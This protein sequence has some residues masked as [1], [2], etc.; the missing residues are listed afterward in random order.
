MHTHTHAASSDKDDAHARLPVP[1]YA[2]A[3]LVLEWV[4]CV[5]SVRVRHLMG[6]VRWICTHLA[7]IR[8]EDRQV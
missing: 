7:V 2:N 1:I 5:Y 4:W 8:A 6:P 3:G